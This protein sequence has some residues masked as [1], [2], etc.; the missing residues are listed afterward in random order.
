MSDLSVPPTRQELT[1]SL[2]YSRDLGE[3][4]EE[5]VG[6]E[7][8][9]VLWWTMLDIGLLDAMWTMLAFAKS[10]GMN[11]QWPCWSKLY[12][13]QRSS[14]MLVTHPKVA[15]P[16]PEPFSL[17]AI[18]DLHTLHS[19]DDRQPSRSWGKYSHR[20]SYVPIHFFLLFQSI[21]LFTHSWNKIDQ[22]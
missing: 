11:A 4:E 19:M 1:Q 16:E 15:W 22:L 17:K 12:Q 13:I 8:R 10:P 14:A 9:L 20:G 3:E 5:E 21:D 2:F 7:F 6:Y 18:I